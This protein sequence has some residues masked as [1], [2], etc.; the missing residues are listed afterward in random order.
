MATAL[1]QSNSAWVMCWPMI[2]RG[3]FFGVLDILAWSMFWCCQWFGIVNVMALSMLWPGQY[4]RT[5]DVLVQLH[6]CRRATIPEGPQILTSPV[7][8]LHQNTDHTETSNTPK[9]RGRCFGMVNV[10]VLS[11]VWYCQCYG[12]IDVLARSIF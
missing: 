6:E 7:H 1:D 3:W 9:R 10:L 8:W 2:W 11:M 12:T 4:F 5:V